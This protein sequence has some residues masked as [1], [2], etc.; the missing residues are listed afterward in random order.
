LTSVEEVILG[1]DLDG[2]KHALGCW[3]LDT[4]AAKFWQKIV[5]DLRN[6][7]VKDILIACCDGLTGLPDA[8]K[9][10]FPDTVVQTC[11]VH[12]IRNAMRFVS[13]GDRKKIAKDMREIYTSPTLDAAELALT[14]FDKHTEP[15]TPARS[16]SG[17]T[18]GTT[19]SRS[20]ITHPSSGK[21]STPPTPSNPST[22]NSAKSPKPRPLPRQR[23]R[24]ETALPRTPL[25]LPFPG[26]TSATTRSRPAG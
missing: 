16:M 9:V 15:S 20:S 21:S 24:H 14:A 2:R 4:E 22:S 18:P 10:I 19:S 3:I 6:R 12:V 7:G 23:R 17:A 25:T 26:S 13:Y 8:I 11:V 5:A 1:V